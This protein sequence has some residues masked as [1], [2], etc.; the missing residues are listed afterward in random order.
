M[1]TL[2]E[3]S[4]IQYDHHVINSKVVEKEK[5]KQYSALV[6]PKFINCKNIPISKKPKQ[7]P[8]KIEGIKPNSALSKI[9]RIYG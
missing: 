5:R 4:K 9:G 2:I 1:F 8:I 6:S 7:K 3:N